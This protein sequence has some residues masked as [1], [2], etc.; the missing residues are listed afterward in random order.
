M[1]M[2]DAGASLLQ[3]YTGLIYSGP[4]LVTALNSSI[5]KSSRLTTAGVD[6]P[7]LTP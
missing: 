1:A 3:L 2:L 5:A 7:N 6:Q 4:G